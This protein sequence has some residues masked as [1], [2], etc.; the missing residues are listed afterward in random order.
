MRRGL[1]DGGPGGDDH[2]GLS[3][4][5]SP[6][7]I[8]GYKLWV[9]A[10]WLARETDG[11]HSPPLHQRQFPADSLFSDSLYAVWLTDWSDL[12]GGLDGLRTRGG[13]PD[14]S[15]SDSRILRI[16]RVVKIRDTNFAQTPVR[17]CQAIALE[18][19]LSDRNPDTSGALF[20][21]S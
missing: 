7:R 10:L 17:R 11:P 2:W 18:G 9:S 6:T 14:S 12:G 5:L 1:V 13:G 19:F 20:D 3:I 21:L 4:C 16:P 15:R 8:C